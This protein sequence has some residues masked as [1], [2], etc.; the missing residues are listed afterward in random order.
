M[1]KNIR[2]LLVLSLVFN[3]TYC[4]SH[5]ELSKAHEIVDREHKNYVILSDAAKYT[6]YAVLKFQKSKK[7][8][9]S[10]CIVREGVIDVNLIKKSIR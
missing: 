1:L 8:S 5:V 2:K 9:G 7:I 10:S 3:L 4:Y 6:D